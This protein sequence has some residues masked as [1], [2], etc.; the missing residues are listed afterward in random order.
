MVERFGGEITHEMHFDDPG[1][2]EDIADQTRPLLYPPGP[3]LYFQG[4]PLSAG[5]RGSL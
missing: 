3:F 5:N 4:L 1:S 2:N